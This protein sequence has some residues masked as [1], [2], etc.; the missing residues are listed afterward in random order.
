MSSVGDPNVDAL[1]VT[2]LQLERIAVRQHLVDLTAVRAGG[3]VA[4]MGRFVAGSTNLR[5]AVI[6]TGAGNVHAALAVQ[7]I[8]TRLRPSQVI[9][10]GVAGGLKDVAIGD[11]VASS[12]VYWIEGGKEA[13]QVRPRPDQAPVSP[14]LVQLARAVAADGRWLTRAATTGGG[15]WSHTGRRPAAVIG[16]VAV[17]ERVLGDQSGRTVE[18]IRDSYGDALTV[19]MED[20]GALRAAA[21]GERTHGLAVRGVSDL[22]CDKAHTDATGAQ[23]LAAANAAAF[24]FELLALNADLSAVG[25]SATPA[26]LLDL[27]TELYPRGPLQNAVWERAG[28]DISRLELSGSG[29]TTWWHAVRLLERGGGGDL[30][31]CDLLRVFVE[32]HPRHSAVSTGRRPMSAG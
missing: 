11:V 32:D 22:L 21:A 7:K 28:G 10:T 9:M 4:D 1:V 19:D 30:E 6:E 2:A 27:A 24:V 5:I 16:P 20:F 14:S 8:E 31:P 13:P 15:E 3:I 17:G 26:E 12:K 18:L 29:R 23:P 25:S